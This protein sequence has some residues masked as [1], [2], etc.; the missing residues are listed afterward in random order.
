ML[1]SGGHQQSG[2]DQLFITGRNGN[3]RS[4]AFPGCF[5]ARVNFQLKRPILNPYVESF[6]QLG[7]NVPCTS[8]HDVARVMQICTNITQANWC[9]RSDHQKLRSMLK[10]K[11]TWYLSDCLSRTMQAHSYDFLLPHSSKFC[12]LCQSPKLID[13]KLGMYVQEEGADQ[14]NSTST[15]RTYSLKVT[16]SLL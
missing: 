6:L 7:T 10:G 1:S 4:I 16:F 15:S 11:N 14:C 5:R 9:P 8:W 3:T 13:R 12:N 2:V